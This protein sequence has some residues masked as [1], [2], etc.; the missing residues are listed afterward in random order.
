MITIDPKNGAFRVSVEY[1][2]D[3]KRIRKTKRLPVGVDDIETA[4]VIERRLL[5]E[6]D[7]RLSDALARCPSG[8]PGTVYALKNECAPGLIKVGMTRNS[9]HSRIK[10]LSTAFPKNWEVVEQCMV[11]DPEHVEGVL[12]AHWFQRRA[13][14]NRELFR[15]DEAEIRKAFALC[16]ELCGVDLSAAIATIGAKR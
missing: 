15:L 11:K 3:G 4:K 13:T 10:N 9:V 5:G 2:K 6:D 1:W 12:H 14:N 16:G 8:K 7:P